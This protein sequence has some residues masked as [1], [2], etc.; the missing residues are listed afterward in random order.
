MRK[1]SRSA[2]LV[3]PAD[4]HITKPGIK[5]VTTIFQTIAKLTS[6][7]ARP[8]TGIKQIISLFPF[9][10]TQSHRWLRF[11]VLRQIPRH[12]KQIVFRAIQ[13]YVL[14]FQRNSSPDYV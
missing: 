9:Q 12:F 13:F 1:R 14:F 2:L 7:F 3:K 10:N 6:G 11:T 4:T 8:E 5:T